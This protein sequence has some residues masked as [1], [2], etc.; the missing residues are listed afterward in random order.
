[1]RKEELELYYFGEEPFKKIRDK[2][3]NKLYEVI[4]VEEL[5]NNQNLTDDEFYVKQ[6]YIL[7]KIYNYISSCKRIRR[8]FYNAYGVV[9]IDTLCNLVLESLVAYEILRN[10]LNVDMFLDAQSIVF[11]GGEDC[12]LHLFLWH[13]QET[14]LSVYSSVESHDY[15]KLEEQPENEVFGLE[16]TKEKN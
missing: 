12:P 9:L 11:C 5:L 3:F 10:N 14:L 6:R 1:M 7:D 13:T 15:D 2:H 8:D 4:G 16:F